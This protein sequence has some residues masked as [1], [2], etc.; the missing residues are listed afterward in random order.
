[1]ARFA[2][3][4]DYIVVGAGTSG[5]VMAAELSRGGRHQVLLVEAGKR[6]RSPIFHIPKGF[7]F[8][9]ENPQH[10]FVYET[11]PFGPLGQTELWSRGRVVGGSSSINGMVW[12]RGT[13]PDW[14]HLARVAANPA[15]S[16]S[17][18]LE[19]YRSIEDHEL[20]ASDTRGAGGPMHISVQ[21]NG[22]PVNEAMLTS[23]GSVGLKRVDDLNASDE[24]RV[25]YVPGN[26]K[27]GIR[28]SSSKVF[29]RPAERR[30]NLTLRTDTLATRI[31]FEGDR[32][33]GVELVAGGGAP[34]VVRARKEIVLCL[35]NME[36]P[37]LLELSGI[38]ARDVLAPLGIDVVVE[39]PR[40]GENVVEHRYITLQ[41]RLND[42]DLGYNR[43]LA[44]QAG[45]MRAG[46]SYLGTRKGPLASPA[47]DTVGFL[48]T[49]ADLD[50]VD[51]MILMTPFSQGIKPIDLTLESR[52]GASIIGNPLRPTTQGSQHI[53]S[54]DPRTNPRVRPNYD[55]DENDRRTYLGLF[56]RM[57]EIAAQP[58]FSEMVHAESSPG[59]AVQSDEA[60]IDHLLL[61][62]GTCFHARGA[63]AVGIDDESVL[64]PQLRVRGVEGLRVMD[65]SVLPEM[66]AGNLNAPLTAMSHVAAR[67]LLD[68]A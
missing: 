51:A 31:L 26:I 58:P 20:G 5:S 57:R 46:M 19:V 67:M 33:A 21:Q 64:D 52:P 35:G 29:L 14:D 68:D 56:R 2:S 59:W 15:W 47:Y 53:V 32:A 63:C 23:A 40:V 36:T 18:V 66:V 4:Y 39:S 11:E 45:Q 41:L 7:A 34:D 54:S 65:A 24:E 1:M 12:N 44:S 22:D 43:R 10:S 48:K 55:F 27:R 13:Q 62:G 61:N 8:T 49:R 50:R 17:S 3:V 30:D 6:D 37:K 16:W 9:V 38:G 60:V 42:P 28:Q 25:G